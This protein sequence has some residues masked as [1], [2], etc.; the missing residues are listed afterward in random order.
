MWEGW[1]V[2]IMGMSRYVCVHMCE[3][4]SCRVRL[5]EAKVRIFIYSGYILRVPLSFFNHLYLIPSIL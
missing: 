1:V 2:C 5:G 3:C 4:V